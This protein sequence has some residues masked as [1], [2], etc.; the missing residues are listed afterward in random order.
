MLFFYFKFN[1]IGEMIMKLIVNV[2]NLTDHF[3]NNNFCDATK[4]KLIEMLDILNV[5]IFGYVNEMMSKNFIDHNE[6]ETEIIQEGK[7]LKPTK[8]KYLNLFIFIY[9]F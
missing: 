7:Y 1:S 2:E 4:K 5:V 3:K 8:I 9:F 6:E